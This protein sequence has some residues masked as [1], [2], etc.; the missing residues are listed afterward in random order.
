M[1]ARSASV[2]CARG[3]RAGAAAPEHTPPPPLDDVDRTTPPSSTRASASPAD[4][5]GASELSSTA[6]SWEAGK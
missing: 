3:L 5:C 6:T 1:A 4:R 2:R